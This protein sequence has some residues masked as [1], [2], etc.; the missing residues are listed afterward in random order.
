M[1]TKKLCCPDNEQQTLYNKPSNPHVLLSSYAKALAHPIRI[2]ILDILKKKQTCI[3][4][5]FVTELPIAQATVSQ[6][7]KVLK[8]AGLIRGTIS[9]PSVCYC[10][11]T[12]NFTEFK[13]LINNF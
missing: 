4:G 8:K 12:E 6:H 10:I 2:K 5:D 13:N 11:N 7:L 3:C 9:G 1:N